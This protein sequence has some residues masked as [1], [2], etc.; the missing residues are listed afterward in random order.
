MTIPATTISTLTD[1]VL[2]HI[3]TGPFLEAVLSNDLAKACA[4]AD[5]DN[6]AALFEIV[7]WINN[8]API[9]CWGTPE[10]YKA[11]IHGRSRS[12]FERTT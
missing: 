9:A 12:L 8:N 1:Y 3:P 4:T 7:L 5:H 6:R 10:K 2:E 11:W